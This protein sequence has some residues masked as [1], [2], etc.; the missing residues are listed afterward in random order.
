MCCI[1]PG[2][3]RDVQKGFAPSRYPPLAGQGVD[4][5]YFYQQAIPKGILEPPLKG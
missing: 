2:A 4:Q 5:A 3:G 1:P